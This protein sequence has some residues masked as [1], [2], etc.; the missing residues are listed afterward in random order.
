MSKIL[1]TAKSKRYFVSKDLVIDSWKD[2]EPYYSNL[3]HRQIQSVDD[4]EKWWKDKSELESVLEEENAWRYIRMVCETQ[5]ESLANHFNVFVTEIDPEINRCNNILNKKLES[6]PFLEKLDQQKFFIAIRSIK[7]ELE[8]F[9][10]ENIPIQAELQ[11]EQQEYGAISA[12]MT[13]IYN[14]KELTLQQASNFLKDTDREVRKNVF[15]LINQRRL[16]DSQKLND[17]LDRLIE[18]RQKVATNAGFD[19]YRDY[20]HV[21]MGRFDYTVKDCEN[22]H[23]SIKEAVLP[24]VKNINLSR[25]NAL[26]LDVLKPYDLDVDTDNKEALKPF[27]TSEEL[28]EKT[29][30]CFAEIRPRFGEFLKI[31]NENKY[32]DLDSRIGKAPGGFNY[33]LYESNVPF[34]FMNSSGNLRDLE[35][36]VHEGGH[37]IHSFLSKDLELVDFKGLTSEIAELASMSMELISM[38]HWYHFFSNEEDLKRAKK[39]QLEGVINVLPWVATIDKFQHWLYTKKNHSQS[40]RIGAWNEIQ[41]EFGTGTVDWSGYEHFKDFVWQKQLHI[42]EVPFYYIEYGI[43]QLGAIAMWRNYKKNPTLTLDNYEK[44]L[45]LGY[46]VPIKQVYET[47]GIKFDFS[48]EYV[49]EL[50]DFVNLELAKL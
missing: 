35:T 13:V 26:K 36:M 11:K 19:N 45:A 10:S 43:S 4:L 17:L 41:K 46:S 28:I 2:I 18:K 50:M 44:A 31:M 25:K 23:E 9:R 22:F 29:I 30:K 38:E 49:Q 27:E 37:A 47:A 20:K 16:Q 32:L 1:D 33:P 24:I 39:S 6:S 14:D 3:E 40:D 48:K 7:K 21:A 15:E 42:Y 34:I 12:Q 8:L 5:N